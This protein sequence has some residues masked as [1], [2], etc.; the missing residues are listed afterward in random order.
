[1]FKP[2]ANDTDAMNIAGDAINIVNGTT[3][4]TLSGDLAIARDQAGLA[5]AKALHD[6]LGA[7]VAALESE[8]NLPAKLADEPPA[9]AGTADN[10]FI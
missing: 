7:I 9:P 5:V 2:F 8:S 3:R 4:L 6:A 1:M 10:P